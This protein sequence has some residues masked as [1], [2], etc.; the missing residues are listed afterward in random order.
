MNSIQR[1]IMGVALIIIAAM[2]LF[3]PWTRTWRD[4]NIKQVSAMGYHF[5]V[6]PPI[7]KRGDESYVIDS[8][9][10]LLQLLVVV[11]IAASAALLQPSLEK[12]RYPKVLFRSVV[13]T[14][15][16][17]AVVRWTV[18][19]GA[20]IFA[21]AVLAASQD[22]FTPS[23]PAGAIR[24]ILF[25]TFMAGVWR[26][27]R[28]EKLLS[29]LPVQAENRGTQVSTEVSPVFQKATTR[30]RIA[31]IVWTLLAVLS[32]C[33]LYF[34]CYGLRPPTPSDWAVGIWYVAMFVSF[35]WIMTRSKAA[36]DN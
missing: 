3:P 8:T 10:M 5:L 24:G 30:R 34:F 36:S 14:K 21:L 20:V 25:V 4:G 28:K 22:V 6:S 1:A 35:I 16:L 33:G 11:S 7:S 13:N 2:A 9:R 29:V 27:T 26:M 15:V 18:R 19:V 23:A 12:S 31:L 17:N 32:Y